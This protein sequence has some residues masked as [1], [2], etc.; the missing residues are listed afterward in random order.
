MRRRRRK[1]VGMGSI[2]TGSGEDLRT[3]VM[4]DITQIRLQL[5][6]N[7]Y[8]PILNRGKVPALTGWQTI[9][10]GEET[11]RSWDRSTHPSTGL[12]A[13][14]GMAIIDVDVAR[15]DLVNDWA[16]RIEADGIMP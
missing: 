2:Q 11:V 4:R 1:I 13:E 7:G 16:R 12:R 9:T 10:I 3:S 15:A 14:R 6:A 5:L 8:V